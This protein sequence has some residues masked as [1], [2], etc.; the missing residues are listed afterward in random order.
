MT[1]EYG[2][3]PV[4]PDPVY[5]PFESDNLVRRFNPQEEVFLHLKV[6]WMSHDEYIQSYNIVQ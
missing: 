5:S 1:N 6:L 4:Y 2:Q 3:L